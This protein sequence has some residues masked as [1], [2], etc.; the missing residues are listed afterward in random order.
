MGV[1]QAQGGRGLVT[2]PAGSIAPGD[3]MRDRGEMKE[4][5]DVDPVTDRLVLSS[6]G[7]PSTRRAAGPSAYVVRFSAMPG[8]EAPQNSHLYVP[9][10]VCVSVWRVQ[11]GGAG[12]T[13]A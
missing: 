1:E 13:M 4:V 3:W 6:S 12:V 11:V 2:V 7:A 9:S 5:A 8:A 10:D